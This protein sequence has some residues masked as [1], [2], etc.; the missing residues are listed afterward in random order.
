MINIDFELDRLR[1]DLKWNGVDM[2]T[3]D[4]IV[5]LAQQDVH[6]AIN[7]IVDNAM[8]EAAQIGEAMGADDFVGQLQVMREN[9]TYHLR[10]LSGKTDFSE[11]PFPMLPKLLKNA[12]TS[13]DGVRYK[14]IPI[15]DRTR[16]AAATNIF[17]MRARANQERRQEVQARKQERDNARKSGSFRGT[18][19]I[20]GLSKAKAY[21]E[22]RRQGNTNIPKGAVTFRTATSNQDPET[23]WVRPGKDKDMTGVL[24]DINDR[25]DQDIEAATM[26]IINQYK[27]LI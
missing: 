8:L 15:A 17:D 10:T 11:P 3:T 16:Q 7:D 19:P 5:N 4:N 9:G 27:E 12:E 2:A 26:D 22:S 23:Q 13:K 18:T 25:I 20:T 24:R 1:N 14:R 6:D 21:L